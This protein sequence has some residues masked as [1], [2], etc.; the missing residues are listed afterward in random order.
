MRDGLQPTNRL[1]IA[2][3]PKTVV[4]RNTGMSAPEVV[5]ARF[6]V[7]AGDALHHGFS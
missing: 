3:Q 1:R 7:L 4:L 5:G 2:E 6:W